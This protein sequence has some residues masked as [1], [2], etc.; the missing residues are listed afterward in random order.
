MIWL[1]N[2]MALVV[3]ATFMFLDNGKEI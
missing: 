3:K 2:S 1:R